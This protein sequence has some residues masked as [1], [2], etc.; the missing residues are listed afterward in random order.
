MYIVTFGHFEFT[1][2]SKGTL[3]FI[4]PELDSGSYSIHYYLDQYVNLYLSKA[5]EL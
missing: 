3:F 4:Y 5:Q 2:V 1:S